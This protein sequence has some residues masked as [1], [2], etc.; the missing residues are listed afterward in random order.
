VRFPGSPAQV[1]ELKKAFHQGGAKGFL[2]MMVSQKA[3]E[4][5]DA[6]EV[7]AAYSLLRETDQAFAWL[8]KAY[9][10]RSPLMEFL[11][12]SNKTESQPFL[13]LF[14]QSKMTALARILAFQR[15][16]LAPKELRKSL[17][18]MPGA[19][20]YGLVC[21]GVDHTTGRAEF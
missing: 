1:A 10:R 3:N 16:R 8:G 15:N 9:R 19:A 5:A 17:E 6:I 21:R 4:G 20:R 7:A 11:I 18:G 2:R 14:L 12:A 13:V